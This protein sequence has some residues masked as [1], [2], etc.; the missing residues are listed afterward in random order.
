MCPSD[1]V[2]GSSIAFAGILEFQT[3]IGNALSQSCGYVT[4]PAVAA[5][6]KARVEISSTY[7]P[8][9]VGSLLDGT[10]TGMR[11]MTSAQVSSG[12][13]LFGDWAQVIMAEWGSLAV[14]V[15][16]Y[17]NFQAGIIGVR[18]LYAM[19]AGLRIPGAFSVASSVT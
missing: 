11:A 9:W 16:P 2:T 12:Y 19:D 8:L 18:A 10:V 17:A 14:E 7:S 4:T 15:N 5:L 6:L 13:I 3:D 1:L